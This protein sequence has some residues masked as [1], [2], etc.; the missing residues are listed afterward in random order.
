[1]FILVHFH[2]FKFYIHKHMSNFLSFFFTRRSFFIT[3]RHATHKSQRARDQGKT[4]HTD[5]RQGCADLVP[6]GRRLYNKLVALAW[7]GARVDLVA[8]GGAA[9]Q[10]VREEQQRKPDNHAGDQPAYGSLDE[11]SG[12]LFLESTDHA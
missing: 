10:I 4:A 12:Y 7:R 9:A 5:T 6:C 1:M 2:S 3:R 11:L 8:A